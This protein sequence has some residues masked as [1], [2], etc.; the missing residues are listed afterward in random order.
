LRFVVA[1]NI[2][3][4]PITQP[5]AVVVTV[6]GFGTGFGELFHAAKQDFGASLFRESRKYFIEGNF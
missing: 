4:R 5:H 1:L 3:E 2:L 6:I